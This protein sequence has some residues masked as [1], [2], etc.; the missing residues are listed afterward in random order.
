MMVMMMTKNGG[1]IDEVIS[2]AFIKVLGF[3]PAQL[4]YCVKTRKQSRKW[5]KQND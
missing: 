1:D 4:T 3:D 5:H 2:Q